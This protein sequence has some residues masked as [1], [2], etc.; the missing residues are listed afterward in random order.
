MNFTGLKENKEKRIFEPYSI[1]LE[2]DYIKCDAYKINEK[3]NFVQKENNKD[4]TYYHFTLTMR[5]I[6]ENGQHT[7]FK[8]TDLYITNEMYKDFKEFLRKD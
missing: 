3:S 1:R 2:K 5:I 8:E 4:V 7:I 6:G